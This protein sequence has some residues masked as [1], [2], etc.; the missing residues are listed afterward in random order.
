MKDD[1]SFFFGQ[2]GTRQATHSWHE[3]VHCVPLAQEFHY[4]PYCELLM[5]YSLQ[6]WG[7]VPTSANFGSA[8]VHYYRVYQRTT[9]DPELMAARHRIML[10]LVGTTWPADGWIEKI[11]SSLD[12]NNP[13]SYRQFYI[14][15]IDG[16]NFVC[17]NCGF[18]FRG[19]GVHVCRRT[20][21]F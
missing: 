14:M 9:T 19:N 20:A 5:E 12:A 11:V 10:Y 17:H 2:I 18:P 15:W 7:M 21:W 8:A 3:N 6:E 13:G 1:K 16:E 4:P